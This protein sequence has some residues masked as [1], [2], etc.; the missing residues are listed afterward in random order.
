MNRSS[1]RSLSAC[2]SLLI[3]NSEVHGFSQ[4]CFVRLVPS[5]PRQCDSHQFIQL[6]LFYC[7]HFEYIYIYNLSYQKSSSSQDHSG[8]RTSPFP[9]IV[10]A[11]Y[12]RSST[13]R[14]WPL[15]V[16]GGTAGGSFK[17]WLIKRNLCS[18]RQLYNNLNL[19]AMK[20]K[21]KLVSEQWISLIAY[22]SWTNL[23][24]SV[25]FGFGF[26]GCKYWKDWWFLPA[27]LSPAEIE[28]SVIILGGKGYYL[29]IGSLALALTFTLWGKKIQH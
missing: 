19:S 21:I 9:S 4:V 22:K 6:F 11:L 3:G 26:V 2:F 18:N 27:H 7:E 8:W 12:Q 15:G 10:Y 13:G 5:K 24:P 14:P 16:R 23:H 20:Q 29:I 17:L 25:Q 1:Q 28:S